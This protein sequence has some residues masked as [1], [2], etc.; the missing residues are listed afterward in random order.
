MSTVSL[1][2]GECARA[3]RPDSVQR[4]AGEGNLLLLRLVEVAG[5]R[6]K[7]LASSPSVFLFGSM[8]KN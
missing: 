1:K 7:S 8:A 3:G 4:L 5:A 6:G 2:F